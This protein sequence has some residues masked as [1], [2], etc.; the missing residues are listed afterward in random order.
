MTGLENILKG[1]KGDADKAADA[2]IKEAEDK[3]SDIIKKAEAE[4][5]QIIKSA[6]EKAK[7]DADNIINRAVSS[8]ELNEKRVY[9][10]E[11]QKLI[12]EVSEGAKKKLE[13]LEGEEYFEVLSSIIKKNMREEK[14]EIIFSLK[15]KEN[16]TEDFFAFLKKN[17]LTVSEDTLPAG[18]KGFIISYSNALENCTFDEIFDAN[19]EI[20]SDK[21]QSFLFS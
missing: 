11:K 8:A 4:A 19:S 17:N 3:A 16:L 9:L 12:K 18:K 15:D 1:I 13:A 14:G 20:I 10:A 2:L 6:E 21:A 7:I 5:G